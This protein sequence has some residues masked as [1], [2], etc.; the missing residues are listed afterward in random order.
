MSLEPQPQEKNPFS[1]GIDQA[2]DSSP[3]GPVKQLRRPGDNSL[4]MQ[5]AA[6]ASPQ[7]V[8]RK[9]TEAAANASPQAMQR[10]A[11][12]AA[13]NTAVIQRKKANETGLPDALKA[14][15]ESL[16]GFSMDHV[17]VVYNSSRPAEVNAL[18]YAEGSVIHV[19]PGQEQ[20]L[21]EEA[22]HIV[23][24]M[25]GRVRPTT[26][27]NG[28]HVNAA[29]D[30]EREAE[31]M[32]AKAL[33]TA[34]GSPQT[35]PKT[36]AAP[37]QQ[38]KQ[39][40]SRFT[41]IVS[42][43]DVPTPI[44]SL[45]LQIQPYFDLIGLNEV[46]YFHDQKSLYPSTYN[47]KYQ[48]AKSVKAIIE[49]KSC[50]KNGDRNSQLIAHY[51]HFGVMERS[52]MG[53]QDRG[54][55]Y[56]GGHLIEHSLMEGSE[57]DVHGNLAPQENKEFNQNLMR[58][59][60]HIPEHYHGRM[61]FSYEM[62]L[63]YASDT[64]TRTGEQ[65]ITAGI[66]HEG[67]IDKLAKIT[68]EEFGTMAEKFKQQEFMFYSWV[69]YEWLAKI[70]AG[71]GQFKASNLNK[72]AHFDK[73]EASRDD[74]RNRVVS[75]DPGNNPNLILTNAGVVS[76]HISGLEVS[77]ISNQE[78]VH[79]GKCK[80]IESHMYSGVPQDPDIQAV[81]DRNGKA[82]VKKLRPLSRK[83]KVLNEPFETDKLISKFH[84]ISIYRKGRGNRRPLLKP[85]T[86]CQK[87]KGG[88]EYE[89]LKQHASYE[90]I[91]KL[92]KKIAK[93]KDEEMST[94][95]FIKYCLG[96]FKED[97][98]SFVTNMYYD[99]N[100]V[101]I[102]RPRTDATTDNTDITDENPRSKKRART[103]TTTEDMDIT[104]ENPRSK[105]RARTETTTD[106]TDITDE[107]PRSKKRARTETTTDHMEI[108][109]DHAD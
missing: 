77:S 5:S 58:G 63:N 103:E 27:V 8:Q 30:L 88:R 64:Y 19:A 13:A 97:G 9:A 81:N 15:I 93:S 47:Q 92:A 49:K 76:G 104:D 109:D 34:P 75:Q 96:Y 91:F 105:K 66:V 70:D 55:L 23:Q 50:G 14:G 79:F 65:L 74:A 6:N 41:E 94:E 18:A 38:V 73:L 90:D 83:V 12:E 20:H 10:K 87:L 39:L 1:S 71:D 29:P 54:N 100:F 51:G 62:T 42:D 28:A 52:I 43:K 106:N 36:A 84:E 24:Q 45:S 3:Q 98:K 57:A 16:S 61:D 25:Q 59:W 80:T 4:Q 48:R 60:E 53:R 37:A 78:R 35:P 31:L 7:V 107:N 108:D 101:G 86:Y 22:W 44:K 82:P 46:Y 68:S 40:K 72:G 33:S 21:P 26:Q 32:G 89:K 67:L 2:F 99:E 11:T 69:P 17:K 56:D 85:Q 95:D 102:K